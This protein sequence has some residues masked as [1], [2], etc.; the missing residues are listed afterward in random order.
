MDRGG[1]RGNPTSENPPFSSQLCTSPALTRFQRKITIK[2]ERMG[3]QT[4]GPTL[5]CQSHSVTELRISHDPLQRVWSY[6][7]HVRHVNVSM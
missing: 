1:Q 5:S 2:E 6:Y 4:G 7:E 3:R